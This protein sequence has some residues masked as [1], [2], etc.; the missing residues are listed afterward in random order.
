MYE[1]TELL[2]S[3][4]GEIVRINLDLIEKRD[5]VSEKVV[6]LKERYNELIKQNAK[7]MFLFCLEA[8][9]F[10][11]KILNLEMENYHKSSSLIQ[12]RI[13]GDYYKLY[14]MMTIQCKDNNI[15]VDISGNFT[16]LP[17]YKDVDPFI[18][19]RIEDISTVHERIMTII[20]I[21]DD[22]SLKK[23][24][25]IQHHCEHMAVGFSLRIF[26]QTLEYENV[27]IKGQ[28]Q[29]FVDYVRFYHASQQTYLEKLVKKIEDFTNELD[30]FVLTPNISELF[31]KTT[32]ESREEQ[33]D[34]VANETSS[35]FC[36][37]ITD[38]E[39]V[40]EVD[41][42]YDEDEEDEE[43]EEEHSKSELVFGKLLGITVP[44]EQDDVL[45]SEPP[46]SS[47]TSN[48]MTE[49]IEP[50]LDCA[51]G[52]PIEVNETDTPI[53]IVAEEFIN[54][55]VD[56]NEN[57]VVIAEEDT[58]ENNSG[59]PDSLPDPENNEDGSYEE[60]SH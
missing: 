1:T 46:V 45:E 34:I 21:M 30:E 54:M 37:L 12:N 43:D 49:P 28:I 44:H 41:D 29:L 6:S 60:S 52:G 8:L 4:F 57:S 16:E 39:I 33:S 35:V 19:Y 42:E 36:T 10:Q 51:D 7:P 20:D 38:S 27:L 56:E 17:V 32:T 59:S 11:Y 9:F 22:L 14:N 18:K 40:E 50:I 15:D 55:V 58:Q 25:N 31:D 53:A 5:K 47:A 24:E 2:R 26:L 3:Q 23:K 13:Y 48:V